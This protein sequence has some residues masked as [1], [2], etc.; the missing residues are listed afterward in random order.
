MK[1]LIISNGHGEDL[2]GAALSEKLTGHK[3]SALPIVGEGKAYEN[4]GCQILGPRKKLPGGGF[5]LRH[6]PSLISDL[7]S[8]LF[9]NILE[10]YRVIKQQNADLVIAIGD[11][12]PLIFSKL[13]KAPLVFIGVNKS[14]YYKWFGYS[15]TPWE[16]Q[17]LKK[18]KIVFTRDQLTA[19]NLSKKGVNAKFVGNPLM[20]NLQL[21]TSNVQTNPKSQTLNPKLIGLLPGTRI[22]DKELN[23]KDFEILKT[24]INKIDKDIMFEIATKE[25]FKRVLSESKLII[26]L[27]GTGNEQAAGLGIPVVSFPGL[28]SQYTKKFG[29]A[30]KQ[31]L[32]DA[33]SFIPE[34]A[35]IKIAQNVLDILKDPQKN[36]SMSQAGKERM[37]GIGAID[38]ISNYVLSNSK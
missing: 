4:K 17:L 1:I 21:P 9:G 25:N 13:V 32:G 24:E 2:V 15:Y 27:S 34:R 5:S 6:L 36:K 29:Q 19:D 11:I 8:G 10:I 14:D 28:G 37:G 30:Q 7:Q 35:F 31:L 26:G 16:I 23:L 3:I 20:N 18:A 33:L 22:K 12:V 38:N